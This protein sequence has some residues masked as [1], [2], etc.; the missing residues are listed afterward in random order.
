[1]GEDKLGNICRPGAFGTGWTPLRRAVALLLQG[2]FLASDVEQL[3]QA[4]EEWKQ[5]ILEL[6][7]NSEKQKDAVVRL[8]H[9]RLRLQE[10]KV[11]NRPGRGSSAATRGWVVGCTCSI[12]GSQ[13]SGSL[14]GLAALQG[15]GGAS[16]PLPSAE[17][18]QGAFGS[19]AKGL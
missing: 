9:L 16:P 4:I 7:D 5:R 13:T 6:P 1:M 3:R 18:P 15:E 14:G 10:L 2:L 8:I 12:R 11:R 19:E 17:W